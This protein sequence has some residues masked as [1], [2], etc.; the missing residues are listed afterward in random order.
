MTLVIEVLRHYPYPVLAST[1][2]LLFVAVFGAV[3]G[4]TFQRR[5]RAPQARAAQLPLEGL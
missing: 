3:I 1:A 5:Q 4:H 2:L